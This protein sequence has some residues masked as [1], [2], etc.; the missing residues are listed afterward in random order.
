MSGGKAKMSG[1][2]KEKSTYRTPLSDDIICPGVKVDVQ[3]IKKVVQ[4]STKFC[5]GVGV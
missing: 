1:G 3:G 2:S 5:P 4:G